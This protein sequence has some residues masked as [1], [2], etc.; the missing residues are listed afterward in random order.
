MLNVDIFD[1]GDALL[2]KL[3]LIV[4]GIPKISEYDDYMKLYVECNKKAKKSLFL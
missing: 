3:C 4:L 1:Y 2:L